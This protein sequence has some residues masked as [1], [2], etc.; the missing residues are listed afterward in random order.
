LRELSLHVLDLI[1]NSVRANASRVRTS[2]ARTG[3]N[4]ERMLRVVVDDNG[5][6]FAAPPD[7]I[8]DPFFTTKPGRRAGLG[9]ALLQATAERT[10]GGVWLAT[11]P[12]LGGARVVADLGD[13]HL[14]RPPVG[15]L[16]STF[17]G[18]VAAHPDVR[19]T[20]VLGGGSDPIHVWDSESVAIDQTLSTVC[21]SDFALAREVHQFIRAGMTSLCLH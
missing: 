5:R 3:S 20:I 4:D 19:W 16:A 11:S 18:M 8:L 10:G 17:L 1:E 9:L 15:D 14:D 12:I 2:L 7:R 6:G 13:E 21:Q